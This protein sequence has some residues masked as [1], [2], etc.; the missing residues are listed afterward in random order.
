MLLEMHREL[1]EVL[2]E[3]LMLMLLPQAL[4]QLQPLQLLLLQLQLLWPP[5]RAQSRRV[6]LVASLGARERKKL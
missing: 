2:S 4:L 5:L 3:P 1:A 6:F